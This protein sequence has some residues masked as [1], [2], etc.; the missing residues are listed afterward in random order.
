M[1]VSTIKT[2]EEQVSLLFQLFQKDTLALP[3]PRTEEEWSM[4]KKRFEDFAE[5]MGYGTIN[6][7]TISKLFLTDRQRADLYKVPLYCAVWQT[8][9]LG[10]DN[11]VLM[12]FKVPKP[13][14]GSSN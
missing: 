14:R 9:F 10:E 7:D 3:P 1:P 5:I 6:Y 12:D 11:P 13:N 2:F 8:I 4:F